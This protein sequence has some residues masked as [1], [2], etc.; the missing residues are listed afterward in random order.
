MMNITSTSNAGT[1]GFAMALLL[2]LFAA[3]ALADGVP[4]GPP[5]WLERW[6]FNSAERTERAVESFA[7]GDAAGAALPLEVAL[8]L[9]GDDPRARI[10]AGVGR[11]ATGRGDARSLLEAAAEVAGGEL[12]SW[13]RY[14]LGNARMAGG[15]LPGAIE[16]Y[17]Q[18]LRGE[19]GHQDAKYNLELARRRLE[20]QEQQDPPP[21]DPPPQDPPPPEE[22]SSSQDQPP[23]PDPS[24]KPNDQ[25]WQPQGEPRQSPLPQ[26]RDLPDMSAE[27]AAAILEAVENMEREGRRRQA[28]EAARQHRPG[29]K[30]W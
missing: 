26:F 7:Q 28:M 18:A 4:A 14:N 10:N 13:A 27:E 3:G 29:E 11:L 6:L 20:E 15:D 2:S 23:P 8:R 25:D 24:Q 12:V 17:R 1:P 16:A 5:P 30:D 22:S 19:P 9:A 21:E